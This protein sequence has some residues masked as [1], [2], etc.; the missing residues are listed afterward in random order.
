[1]T[2]ILEAILSCLTNITEIAEGEEIENEIEKI[3]EI[4]R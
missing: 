1:M 2:E 4:V 3:F